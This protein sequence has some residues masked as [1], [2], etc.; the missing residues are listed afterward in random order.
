[1]VEIKNWKPGDQSALTKAQINVAFLALHGGYGEGGLVQGLLNCLAIPYTGT[2]VLGL[3]IALDKVLSKRV[4]VHA[5]LVDPRF[6][7]VLHGGSRGG[8]GYSERWKAN[9]LRRQATPLRLQRR[10]HHR[11]RYG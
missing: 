7:S 5:G 2:G 9:P 4:F 11:G 6:L 3:A 8:E 10:G 1:M